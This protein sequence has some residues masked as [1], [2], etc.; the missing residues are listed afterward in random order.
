MYE[1]TL[2]DSFNS[3]I[4]L[5]TETVSSKSSAFPKIGFPDKGPDGKVCMPRIT[6]F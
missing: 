3:F 4:F 1:Q 6:G 5:I 2:Q